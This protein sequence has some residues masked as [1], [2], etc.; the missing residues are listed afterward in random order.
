MNEQ[1][2]VVR[3]D[4]EIVEMSNRPLQ[5]VE[6]TDLVGRVQGIK[7]AIMKEGVHFGTIPGC[8]DKPALLQPGADLL[9]MAFRLLPRYEVS[10]RDLGNG[11]REYTVITTLVGPDGEFRGQGIGSA[12][13]LESK[14]RYRDGQRKCP[15]CGAAAIIKGKEEYGGGWLC[16]AK[17]GGCGAKFK[18]GDKSIEGQAVG[19]V[20]NPD[21]A[22]QY[23]TCL[24]IAMKR[25]KVSGLLTATASSDMFTQDIE[26]NPEAFSGKTAPP[27]RPPIQ[28][29]TATPPPPADGVERITPEQAR[30]LWATAKGHGFTK[31]QVRA[32]LESKGLASTND[33]PLADLSAALKWAK[34]EQGPE[35]KW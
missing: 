34:G 16:F 35:D 5:V 7:K 32:K 13:T 27:E 2:I 28:E 8:G 26:D 1:A 3:A 4:G 9:S 29:P 18:A 14:W 12:S 21:I 23:N 15:E 17:K 11:H 25:S 31:E 24:K 19:K 10:M 33:L 22:D 6:V 30:E 20:E